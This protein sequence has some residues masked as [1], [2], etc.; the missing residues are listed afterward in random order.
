MSPTLNQSSQIEL[1][2]ETKLLNQIPQRDLFIGVLTQTALNKCSDLT[3]TVLL[4]QNN[5]YFPGLIKQPNRCRHVHCHRNQEKHMLFFS[6][7]NLEAFFF[8]MLMLINLFFFSPLHPRAE[9]R[10]KGSPCLSPIRLWELSL[11]SKASDRCPSLDR[12]R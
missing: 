3:A 10:D 12:E 8:L 4:H 7:A 2:R 9:G 11:Q 6:A 1:H 5:P